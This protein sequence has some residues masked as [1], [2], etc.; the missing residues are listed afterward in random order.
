MRVGVHVELFR[1]GK[2]GVKH[3]VPGTQTYLRAPGGR[4][5]ERW[6]VRSAQVLWMLKLTDIS[7]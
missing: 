1:V 5:K 3:K 6:E 2:M 4:G 7:C